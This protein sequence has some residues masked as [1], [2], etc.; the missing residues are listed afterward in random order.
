M[1]SEDRRLDRYRAVLFEVVT[2]A[3]WQRVVEAAV[4][5]AMSGHDRARDWVQRAIGVA[6]ALRDEAAVDSVL[7][8]LPFATF[9]DEVAAFAAAEKG[10]RALPAD[11]EDDGGGPPATR[12]SVYW[13]VVFS[14]VTDDR[15][16]RII[17]VALRQALDGDERAREWITRVL[18]ANE[19]A[20]QLAAHRESRRDSWIAPLLEDLDRRRAQGRA[21]D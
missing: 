4:I 1:C 13:N 7:L 12:Y 5:D 8:R 6:G 20:V 17:H 14:V 2:E 11:V 15:W 18:G 3:E 10:I 9:L 16:R 19:A 21:E